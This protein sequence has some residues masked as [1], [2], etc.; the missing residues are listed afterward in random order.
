[1]SHRMQMC[2]RNSTNW[3]LLGFVLMSPSV[4]LYAQAQ[5]DDPLLQSSLWVRASVYEDTHATDA[6][7][8]KTSALTKYMVTIFKQTPDMSY[9]QLVAQFDFATSAIDRTLFPSSEATIAKIRDYSKDLT[10][11]YVRPLVDL[12]ADLSTDLVRE[13]A[14]DDARHFQ[15]DLYQISLEAEGTF[16]DAYRLALLHPDTFGALVNRDIFPRFLKLPTNASVD[17]IVNTY[18]QLNLPREVAILST[19]KGDSAHINEPAAVQTTRDI[20]T[21]ADQ[22]LRVTAKPRVSSKTSGASKVSKRSLQDIQAEYADAK[23]SVSILSTFL[24]LSGDPRLQDLAR[25]FETEVSAVI[26]FSETLELYRTTTDQVSDLALF[27]SGL[28]CALIIMTS[29]YDNNNNASEIGALNDIV[30]ELRSLRREMNDHF[31]SLEMDVIRLFEALDKISSILSVQVYQLDQL[32]R[33]ISYA[34]ERLQFLSVRANV[35]AQT[36]ARDQ[37]DARREHCL[38]YDYRPDLSFPEFVNCLDDFSAAATINAHDDVFEPYT[39]RNQRADAIAQELQQPLQG[40]L[41][42]LSA[43]LASRGIT[44]ERSTLPNPVIWLEAANAYVDLAARYPDYFA[45]LTSDKK[46]HNIIEEG[47]SV[48][49]F[50]SDIAKAATETHSKTLATKLLR[51]YQAHASALSGKLDNHLNERLLFSVSQKPPGS[52]LRIARMIPCG[53]LTIASHPEW[54]RLRNF[55]DWPLIYFVSTGVFKQWKD[56]TIFPGTATWVEMSGLGDIQLCYSAVTAVA[57]CEMIGNSTGAKCKYRVNVVGW[58]G[59]VGKPETNRKVFENV[60]EFLG[61]VTSDLDGD[62]KRFVD[63]GLSLDVANQKNAFAQWVASQLFSL[64]A[65]TAVSQYAAARLWTVGPDFAGA[66]EFVRDELA[67]PGNSFNVEAEVLAGEKA[68]IRDAI[69]LAF[70]TEYDRNMALRQSLGDDGLVDRSRLTDA[71]G[72][73]G[74]ATTDKGECSKEDRRLADAITTVHTKRAI[75]NAAKRDIGTIDKAIRESRG[76]SA[77]PLIEIALSRLYAL[78][79]AYELNSAKLAQAKANSQDVHA[80]TEPHP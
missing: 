3:I 35:V 48:T 2:F 62:F 33:E 76:T 10:G 34:N 24:Q 50:A 32:Q 37:L 17:Q 43:L 20:A 19:L 45:H 58:V 16:L 14:A 22:K 57:P 18:P 53:S 4:P 54:N 69:K 39:G 71:F 15:S 61:V 56:L 47:R 41:K 30:Q 13:R 29:I 70:P 8:Y 55:I 36:Q 64:P 66:G 21:A 65:Q 72:C 77:D 28:G 74:L 63:N 80:E 27:K 79:A 46:L 68:I 59:F 60:F 38:A 44:H 9:S 5:R 75:E 7:R 51:P 40:N 26:S 23:D 49:V 25:R 52:G 78:G 42:Y 1:M 12:A 67:S 31:A 11:V 6:D 73:L